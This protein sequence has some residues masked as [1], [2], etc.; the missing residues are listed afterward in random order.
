MKDNLYQ[1]LKEIEQ[2][3]TKLIWKSNESELLAKER[4]AVCF[5]CSRR[6]KKGLLK[7]TCRVCGCYIPAKARAIRSSC[8]LK[9]WKDDR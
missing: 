3:W 7:N 6:I 4:L 9:Y 5:D 2:G 1:M 8:P